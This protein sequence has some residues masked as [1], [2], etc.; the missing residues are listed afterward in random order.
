MV[1]LL[2]ASHLKKTEYFPT[3]TPD[4]DI[5]RSMI[6][7][8]AGPHWCSPW[9]VPPPKAMMTS[10]G[11]ASVRNNVDVSGLHRPLRP[12]WCPPSWLLPGTM[13]MSITCASRRPRCGKG[14]CWYLWLLLTWESMWMSTVH[15]PADWLTSELQGSSCLWH[16]NTGNTEVYHCAWL[17]LCLPGISTCV[18]WFQ[19]QACYWLFSSPGLKYFAENW[20]SFMFNI[21]ISQ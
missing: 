20:H 7:L 8:K 3:Y 14:L 10:I 6:L 13:L 1:K 16:H 5:S 15:A 18:F 17:F 11:H 12:C 19:K 9:S 4:K 21:Q 2:G